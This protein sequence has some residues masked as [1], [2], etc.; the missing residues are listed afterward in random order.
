MS[1]PTAPPPTNPPARPLPIDLL[2]DHPAN[3]NVMPK[4][5]VEKLANEIKRTG[6]YP[7]VI[8]RSVGE[9]YQVL[10]G[11]HRVAVLRGLGHEEVQAVVWQ[12][13]DE[14]ALLLLASLN[15][16]SGSDDPRKRASLIAQL[17]QS[18]DLSE[19]AQRLP[20]DREKVRKLLELH[21]AP[22]SPKAPTPLD[23]LP[24]SV[25][26]F[27]LPKQR[28]AVERRLKEQGGT[29]EAALLS[30]LGIDG[31]GVDE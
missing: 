11:H 2:D 10:D 19:L 4:A 25:H 20:E 7:P 1:Q 24:V 31:G 18:L 13:D 23:A 12:A 6:L 16:L 26:F 8:V 15:R 21:A 14:Q 29:R 3:S 30:L 28:S 9:R 5:L 27:M 17:N 22:P